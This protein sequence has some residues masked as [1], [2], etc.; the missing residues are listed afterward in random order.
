MDDYSGIEQL[1]KRIEWLDNE[2]RNDK[3][4]LAS[5][6]NRLTNLESENLNLRKQIKELEMLITKNSN[7]IATLDKYENRIDRLNIDL[8]KQIR[9]VNERADL[10]LNE[11]IKRIKLEIEATRK[12]I[13]E[14]YSVTEELENVRTEM[15]TYKMEVARLSRLNEELKEKVQEVDRFDEDYRRSLHLLE[16]N[17]R[18]EAKRLTDLQGEVASVRKRLE[19]TRSRFD[20]IS[21]SFRILDTRIVELQTFEKDRKQAQS[22]FIEKVNHSLMEKDKTFAIWEKRFVEIDD[23]NLNLNKKMN[24]LETARQAVAKIVNSAEE[25]TQRFERRINEITEFQRLN[26]ERF[27]QEWTV[28]KSDDV[29]RWTNYMLSQEEQSRENERQFKDLATQCQELDDLT[30]SLRSQLDLL[31]KNTLRHVQ[32]ILLA[33]QDSIQDIGPTLDQ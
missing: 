19:E 30:D 10:N 28:F 8:S 14:I 1:E 17:R 27:R 5:L 12:S 13:A 20:S 22:V 15:R 16:E 18:L 21:D 4:N 6:Q 7:Q 11:A 26:D 29:K 2:R 23:V 33:Y 31:T 3:T 9:D 32:S 24:E 25:V